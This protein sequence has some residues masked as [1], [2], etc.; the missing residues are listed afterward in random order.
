[1]CIG[2]Y[3]EKQCTDRTRGVIMI[4][5]DKGWG[6][7]LRKVI[8]YLVQCAQFLLSPAGCQGWHIQKFKH[9]L[10]PGVSEPLL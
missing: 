10:I 9:V 4:S 3:K 2:M 1:M 8:N 7:V 6:R 5:G